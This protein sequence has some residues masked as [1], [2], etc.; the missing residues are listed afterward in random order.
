MIVKGGINTFDYTQSEP[1]SAWLIAHNMGRLPTCDVRILVN[2]QCV[3][4][5]PSSVQYTDDNTVIVNF[6]S[7]QVGSVRLV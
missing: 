4:I 5:L 6:T 3:K 7:A 2:G 1:S